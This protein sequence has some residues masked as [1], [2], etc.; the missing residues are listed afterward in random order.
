M[1]KNKKKSQLIV[2]NYQVDGFLFQTKEDYEKAVKEQESVKYIRA[3]TD[4]TKF[5]MVYKL[6]HKLLEKNAFETIIGY[7]F[8]EELRTILLER[9]LISEEKIPGI[10]IR[11]KER[12]LHEPLKHEKIIDNKY[13]QLYED[14]K[15]KRFTS[16]IV[17]VFLVGIIMAMLVIFMNSTHA[18][19][20]RV[21]AEFENKYATWQQE[22]E[23]K[24]D[25]LDQREKE[26]NEQLNQR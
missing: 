17:N 2:Y 26:L 4:F 16:R 1:Q 14:L 3:N 12:I 23:Q 24:Q 15:T 8:L 21:E 10:P 25:E 6:Y 7:T 19:N 11:V 9:N 22:L 20:E 13:K 5:Q 18:T